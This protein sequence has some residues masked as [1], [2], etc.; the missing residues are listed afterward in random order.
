M[1]T[2]ELKELALHVST[3]IGA[4]CPQPAPEVKG[5]SPV[6]EAELEELAQARDDADADEVLERDARR[7]DGLRVGAP[8][9]VNPLHHLRHAPSWQV[10]GDEKEGACNFN[11]MH[12]DGHQVKGEIQM[13]TIQDADINLALRWHQ[14][15]LKEAFR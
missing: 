9:A 13:A 10:S 3:P 15:G 5:D 6:E 4:P 2:V 1:T 14:R 12:P 11:S 7:A 8:D